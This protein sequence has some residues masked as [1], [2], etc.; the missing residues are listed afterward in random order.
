MRSATRLTV[1]FALLGIPFNIGIVVAQPSCPTY[2]RPYP[3]DP[4]T[5]T[6]NGL[7]CYWEGQYDIASKWWEFAADQ[8]NDSLAQFYLG[9]LFANGQGVDQDQ[10]TATE[11]FRAAA[12]QGLPQAQYN[13]GF[14]LSGGIGVDRDE[15]AALNQIIAAADQGLPE[16]QYDIGIRYFRGEG[17]PKSHFQSYIWLQVASASGFD[18]ARYTIESLPWDL[19]DVDMRMAQALAE[20]VSSRWN[21]GMQYKQEP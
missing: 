5:S 12:E 8:Q 20:S 16:A 7:R 11:W 13:Y 19:D 4:A 1:L 18:G 2:S 10:V 6:D 9:S 14:R 15:V 17:L 3:P 21:L